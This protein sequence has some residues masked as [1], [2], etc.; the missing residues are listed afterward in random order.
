MDIIFGVNGAVWI[1]PWTPK[2]AA[3]DL[4]PQAQQQADAA[5]LEA[6]WNTRCSRHHAQCPPSEHN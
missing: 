2:V 5:A 4:P 1:A 6:R 3:A